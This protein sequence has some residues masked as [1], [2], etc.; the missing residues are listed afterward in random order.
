MHLEFLRIEA[1][2]RD[3]ATSVKQPPKKEPNCIPAGCLAVN[4]HVFRNCAKISSMTLSYQQTHFQTS[5]P[6]S[7]LAPP[8]RGAEVAFAGRSNAGKSSALNAITQQ[9][10]LARTSKTPGR[11]QQLNFF[12]VDAT[13]RLVDLPGYGYAKVPEDVKLRW[14]HSLTRYLE[15]RRSL[16]GLILVMDCRHPL[17][18][19]DVQLLSWCRKADLP[20]HVLLSKADKLRRGPA[21]ATLL[22]V[23]K[24]LAALHPAGSAQLFSSLDKTGVDEARS[25]LDSWLEAPDS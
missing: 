11:T 23:T 22:A 12:A 6:D 3:C 25:V 7:R 1:G 4:R 17:T 21:S 14:Q 8:D 19:Y 24:R 20:V 18:D 16:R 9:R 5:V 10:A 2:G 15:T 13:R